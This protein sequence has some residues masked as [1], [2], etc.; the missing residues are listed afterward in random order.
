MSSVTTEESALCLVSKSEYSR[1]RFRAMEVRPDDHNRSEGPCLQDYGSLVTQ[2]GRCIAFPNIYQHL[3]HPF[4]LVDKTKPGKRTIVV[5]FLCDPLKRI[6]STTDVPP[7]QLEWASTE[8]ARIRA[9][10]NLPEL[11]NELWDAVTDE[12]KLMS[13]EEAKEIRLD[14]MKERKY[15]VI[16]N[17]SIVYQ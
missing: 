12:T 15:L 16:A 7:Q 6:P 14:L 17:T 4:E 5:F 3:V 2:A 9:E 1:L 8:M 13:L 11:P 10:A